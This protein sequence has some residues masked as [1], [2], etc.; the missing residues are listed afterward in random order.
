[1]TYVKLVI[2]VQYS[3]FRF[4][5]VAG[6]ATTGRHGTDAAKMEGS[7]ARCG[8]FTDYRFKLAIAK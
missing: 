2:L 1:M 8:T 7:S 6:A 5:A 4:V 3:N